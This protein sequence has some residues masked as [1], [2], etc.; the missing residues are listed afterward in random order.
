MSPMCALPRFTRISA[1]PRTS[2]RC[3]A[4]LPPL[5]TTT[6]CR[7]GRRRQPLPKTSSRPHIKPMSASDKDHMAQALQLA[8]RG[9]GLTWPNPSV[10]SIVVAPSGEIVGR[11]ST[12]PGGRPHAEAIALDRAGAKA[13]GATVYVTLEP[14]AHQGRGLACADVIAEAK[15]ARAVIALR[16]PDPR[17]SGHGVERLVA[18]GIEVEEGVLAEEAADVAL[19]HL[20]RVT[21]DRPAVTLK[22]AVGGDGLMPRGDGAP[23][24]ITGPDAR[25]H[26]HLL[27]AR[28][29][30]ILVGRGTVL[31]DNPSLTC[32]LPGMSCRS[33]VRV[34]LDR[35]L[36]TPPHAHLFDDL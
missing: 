26:G 20:L 36:R 24:W 12:A 13:R 23:V 10:G 6:S 30:A 11:G 9:L 29:D 34:V 28:H 7:P 19:G 21:E 3:S 33:P 18:A 31:A 22:L 27:R 1:R 8:R 15:P 4:S 32:R 16:D 14:C 5:T 35:R 17:T 25:A 2:R